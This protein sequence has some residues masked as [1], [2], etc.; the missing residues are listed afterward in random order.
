MGWNIRFIWGEGIP[1]IT[2]LVG[3]TQSMMILVS[4][5]TVALATTPG[6]PLKGQLYAAIWADLE[7]NAMIGNGNWPASLW[8]NASSGKT[9][10]LHIRQLQCVQTDR[11]QR[12][13][14]ELHRDNGPAV[15]LGESAPETL[16]CLASFAHDDDGGAWS[17]RHTP[18][19]GHSR[20]TM[21]CKTP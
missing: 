11:G 8:Y 20:T 4:A 5:L 9:P 13:S 15:V 17:V 19:H 14:F 7:L 6:E 1:A 10:D 18:G 12:C 21:T 3:E 2:G 16:E